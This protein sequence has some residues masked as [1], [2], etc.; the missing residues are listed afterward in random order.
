MMHMK[1]LMFG[2]SEV[3][4]LIMEQKDPR[5]QK[6][7]GREVRNFDNELWF[8]ECEPMMVRGLIS[9]F[10]QHEH[11]LVAL[12]ETEGKIL[13]EASPHDSIWGIGMK[14]DHPDILDPLKWKGH[15]LLGRSLMNA[16]RQI[17]ENI[18]A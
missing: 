10:T 15:N 7:L 2:D 14:E 8:E 1:A 9:K 16:R 12:L 17:I 3:A 11:L 5:A 6:M 13:V 4:Q 18:L